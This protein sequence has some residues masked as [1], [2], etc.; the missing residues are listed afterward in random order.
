MGSYVMPEIIESEDTL[1]KQLSQQRSGRLKERVQVAYLVKSGQA[2]DVNTLARLVGRDRATVTRWLERYRVGG[3]E[4]L[5][6]L[7]YRQCGRP[8]MLPTRVREALQTRLADPEQSFASYGEIQQWL[9]E[10]WGLTVKYPTV[11][12]IVRYQ[13]RAKLKVPRPRH[14]DQSGAEVVDFK[15]KATPSPSDDEGTLQQ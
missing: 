10:D 11:H 8:G 2:Q 4:R 7:G 6:A 12:R 1:K 15:K 3:L 9:A 5:V 13:L 14:I